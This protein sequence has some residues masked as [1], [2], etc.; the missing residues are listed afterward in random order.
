MIVLDAS[1][2]LELL[3]RT[4]AGALVERHLVAPTETFHAPHL[5]DVEVA[6]VLRRYERTRAIDARRGR[7]ALE[8][9]ADLDLTRYAHDDLLPRVWALRHGLSAYDATYVALAEALNAPL[10]TCDARLAGASGHHAR[11]ELVRS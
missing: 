11:I 4:K 5:L 3:L 9:L 10:L 2:V 6:Q 7:E 1:A 8:D